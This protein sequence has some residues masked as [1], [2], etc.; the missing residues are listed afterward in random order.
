MGDGSSGYKV[1]ALE[2][3]KGQSRVEE[4]RNI[5]TR[6]AKQVRVDLCGCG[7]IRSVDP[8]MGPTGG[9]LAAAPDHWPPHPSDVLHAC[10]DR[11]TY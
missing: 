2:V 4:A 1:L 3:L 6:V 5:L 9:L 10:D 11:L 8:S 7:F